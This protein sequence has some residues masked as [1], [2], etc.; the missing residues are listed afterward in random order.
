M[1][2]IKIGDVFEIKTS[3]G[4]GYIQYVFA[5]KTVGELIR[6]FPKQ[7]SVDFDEVS[8][9]VSSCD[10]YFVHFPLKAALKKEIVKFVENYPVPSEVKLPEQM[11]SRKVDKDGNFVSWQIVDYSTWQR[12]NVEKLSSSDKKLSPWGTWNDTLL[13]ERIEEGWTPEKW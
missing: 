11:R 12:T 7:Y 5:N 3:K 10:Y 9:V 4:K 13:V 2:R 8:N 6:V 1:R